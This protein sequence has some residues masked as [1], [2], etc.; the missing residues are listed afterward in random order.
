MIQVKMAH[1]MI[2]VWGGG[3]KIWGRGLGLRV[4][5]FEFG[6]WKNLAPA[7]N[8]YL[9]FNLCQFYLCHSYLCHS[10]LKSLKIPDK[11]CLN[12]TACIHM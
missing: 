6:V 1:F 10:Y 5:G 4:W 7:C 8:F 11:N 9:L 2:R 3:L 12:S